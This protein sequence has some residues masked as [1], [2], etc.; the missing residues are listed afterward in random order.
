MLFRS[1]MLYP[2]PGADTIYKRNGFIHPLFSP[3]GNVLTRVSPP[4]H[5]HHL[6][7]WNPWTRV[8]I[9]DHVTDF[10]NLY[11]KQGTVRFAGINSVT[12]GTVF[13]GFSVKHDH[14]DF[15]GSRNENPAINEV[16]DIRAWNVEPVEGTSGWL[17]DMTSFLSVTG[18]A[19]V[20]IGRA[21]V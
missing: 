14:I 18:N 12:G 1:A 20:E 8:R 10:W 13:G 11:E 5:Y 6:G 7:I 15:Q 21:H 9:G 4:D 2:P 19:P 16:W 17:V 3:S